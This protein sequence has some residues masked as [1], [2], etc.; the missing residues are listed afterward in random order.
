MK[1]VVHFIPVF[2]RIGKL[3]G[4]DVAIGEAGSKQ[5]IDDDLLMSLT[6]SEVDSRELVRFNNMLR[7]SRDNHTG[8]SFIEKHPVDVINYIRSFPHRKTKEKL[9]LSNIKAEHLTHN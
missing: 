6:V 4:Y 9:L 7:P 5:L 2:S 1:Y 8:F 3:M